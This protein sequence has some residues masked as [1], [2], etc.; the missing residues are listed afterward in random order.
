MPDSNSNVLQKLN[1]VV[2]SLNDL[3]HEIKNERES[4]G[5]IET[6]V[7]D[8]ETRLRNLEFN[9]AQL[10]QIKI[11]LGVIGASV[12]GMAIKLFMMG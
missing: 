1:E 4:R 9:Q 7:E 6:K 2:L 3:T 11:I 5:R 10:L 12:V 8:H